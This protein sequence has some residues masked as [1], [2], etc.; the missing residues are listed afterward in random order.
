MY[1]LKN[2][3]IL[4]EEKTQIQAYFWSKCDSVLFCAVGFPRPQNQNLN[5]FD[6]TFLKC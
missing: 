6:K 1:L 2:S 4:P 3:E 5:W